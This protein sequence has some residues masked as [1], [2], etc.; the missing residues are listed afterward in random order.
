[1]NLAT[2]SKSKVPLK[3][4]LVA[5]LCISI[6]SAGITYYIVSASPD[7]ITILPGSFIKTASFIIDKAGS[8]YRSWNG[9][10]GSLYTSGTNASQ[11]ANNCEDTLTMGGKILLKAGANYTF[12]A[13]LSVTNYGVVL[14]GEA[15]QS[16]EEPLANIVAG[17]SITDLIKVDLTTAV[18]GFEIRNLCLDGANKGCNGLTLTRGAYH[19]V[20]NVRILRCAK[21]LNLIGIAKSSFRNIRLQQNTHGLYLVDDDDA[22]YP[23]NALLLSRVDSIDN[24]EYGI[25]A[26]ATGAF[27][28]GLQATFEE[29]LIESNH[30]WGAYFYNTNHFKFDH[31]LFET[32]NKDTESNIDDLHIEYATERDA[33][34]T[35]EDCNFIGTDVT[36]SLN[37]FGVDH[38]KV[39]RCYFNDAVRISYCKYG[40]IASNK[41][42]VAPTVNTVSD[43]KFAGNEGYITIAAGTA[44]ASN[45]DWVSFGVTFAGTPHPILT[46][47]ENDARYIAQPYSVNTTHFRLY[48][49]DETAGALETVDKTINWYAEYNP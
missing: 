42:V 48:L 3:T 38:I 39:E 9:S 43:I 2:V 11:I 28:N 19:L 46:V 4:L 49:Y 10:D 30:K 21:G 45:T 23:P 16:A 12:D 41:F 34:I 31:C 5:I 17:A 8:T 37:L 1:M 29:C 27:T 13:P 44:E 25:Y 22:D 20:E 33:F 35:V 18:G 40:D 36:Y 7:T 15:H 26:N 32:N 14:E 24:T 47:E 6:L